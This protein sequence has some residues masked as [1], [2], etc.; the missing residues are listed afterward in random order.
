MAQ[1]GHPIGERS[2][3][4]ASTAESPAPGGGT[5][6]NLTGDQNTTAV[7]SRAQNIPLVVLEK[8]CS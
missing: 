2:C 6:E 5:H 1:P 7:F 4:T 8:I 3:V